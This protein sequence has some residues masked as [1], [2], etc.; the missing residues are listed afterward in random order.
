LLG[1]RDERSGIEGIKNFRGVNG[2]GLIYLIIGVEVY[3]EKHHLLRRKMITRNLSI[4]KGL[5]C[6]IVHYY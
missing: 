1:F 3:L 5:I 4:L 2:L 6:L